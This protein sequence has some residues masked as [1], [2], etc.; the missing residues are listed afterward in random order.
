MLVNPQI[1][2]HAIVPD[3]KDQLALTA[4]RGPYLWKGDQQTWTATQKMLHQFPG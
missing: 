2:T 1:H 4:V 3:E